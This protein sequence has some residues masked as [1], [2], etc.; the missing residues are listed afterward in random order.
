MQKSVAPVYINNKQAKKEIRKIILFT[1]PQKI[2][3]NTPKQESK[4]LLQSKLLNTEKQKCVTRW[5]DLLYS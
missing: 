3:K 1:K 4:R 2:T 5:E